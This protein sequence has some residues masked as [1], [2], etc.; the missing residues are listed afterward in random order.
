MSIQQ[1]EQLIS[2]SHSRQMR[3]KKC[4]STPKVQYECEKT[5]LALAYGNQ[6]HH[7]VPDVPSTEKAKYLTISLSVLKIAVTFYEVTHSLVASFKA[8]PFGQI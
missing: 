4:D 2:S 6:T 8:E 3:Q 5:I 1:S 7:Y